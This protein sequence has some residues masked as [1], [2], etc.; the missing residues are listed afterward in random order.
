[1]KKYKICFT[2]VLVSVILLM[3][4]N[5]FAIS[6]KKTY[7][8]FIL[9][10]KKIDQ[11]EA[12]IEKQMKRGKIPGI[13]V[14]VVKGDKVIYKKGFGYSDLDTKQPVTTDTLFEMGSTSKA[15]SALGIYQ[16]EDK[17]LLSLK[18]PVKKYLPWL[19]MEY[20]GTFKGEEIDGFV[21][22]TLQQLLHHTSGIPFK[23]IGDIPAS[24]RED[25]L[26]K[27]VRK[28]L[29][30]KLDSYPGERYSY[31][32]INYDVLGLVIQQVSG[33]SFEDY[34]KE[35]VIQPIGLKNTVLFRDEAIKRDMSK[36][37]KI[38]YL[39]P[40]KYDAPMYR[41]NTPAGYFITNAEDMI[42]WLRIQLGIE[43]LDNF[44]NDI[45]KKS[46]IPDRSVS[47]NLDGSSYAGGWSV[48][49]NGGGEISH[50]G[51][52][53]NFSSFIVFRPED[54][55]GVAVLANLNSIYTQSIGQGIINMIQGND[56]MEIN[57]DMYRNLDSIAVSIILIMS[58]IFLICL[59]MTINFFIQLYKKE[60]KFHGSKSKAVIDSTLFLLFITGFGYC[61]YYIPN[62]LFWELPW[63]FV[64][65]WAPES[66]MV[67]IILL[68]FTVVLLSLY[69]LLTKNFVKEDDKSIFYITTL[70]IVSGFGNAF[71]IFLINEALNRS[72]NFT[73][74]LL[75]Y[76]VMALIIYIYGQK[77]VRVKLT[78]ITNNLVYS[79]RV[80][81]I[82][83][84]LNTSYEKMEEIG[85]EKI[86]ACLNNDT[87]TISNFANII[88]TGATSLVTLLCCFAYLG[89]INF[90]GLLVSIVIIFM[91]ACLYFFAGVSANR[92]WEQ[93]RNIQAT[94]FKFINDMLNGFKELYIHNKKRDEFKQD[95]E[96]SCNEYKDK[97]IK[98]DL[99]FTNAFIIGE[100]LFTFVIGVV[101]FIF[102][103]IFTNIQKGGLRNYVLVFLYMTGPV[104]SILEAI[105]NLTKVRIS[106]NRIN[107]LTKEIEFA[108]IKSIKLENYISGKELLYL[109]LRDIE[110]SYKKNENQ[111]FTVGPINCDFKAG[112][113]TFITGGNGSGKSSLAKLITGLYRPNKGH[114]YL[115]GIQIGAEELSQ[116][117]STIFSD[118]HLFD[119]LYGID[120]KN[121]MRETQEYLKI[122]SIDN[123]LQ[124]NDGIFSTTNLST[125]QRKRIALLISYLENRPIYLFDEWAADQDP[126]FRKFFYYTL[127]PKLRDEGKCIIAI[128]H[129]D[130]YFD[131]ADKFIKMDMGKIVDYNNYN[132]SDEVI[133]ET[134][135]S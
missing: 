52:N 131:V 123:K 115:N 42:K 125:G 111:E 41:G 66:F 44:N 68:F 46:H 74:G 106:W 105:P 103:I 6:Y 134:M 19:Q 3:T 88:I 59:W 23:T 13:S 64:K 73:S 94:F 116:K 30:T 31:A 65:V 51:S 110:Y 29:E 4:M 135:S 25:A 26:E 119:R 114:I 96:E 99:K 118:F 50:G 79:K 35:N 102:P 67:S 92:L 71:I 63:S 112:E 83:R 133:K 8:A 54:K 121:K 1:M 69:F 104:R 126:E 40:L 97:R 76:F 47:P 24:N 81:L 85:N 93:T 39:Q 86:Y 38:G 18:D 45:I 128:T 34:M 84:I 9:S 72:S 87:E 27:T 98:G 7:N 124:V 108:E 53:P 127:L 61:L 57:S 17:G 56:P 109:E 101:V 12:F 15:F 43:D 78:T 2:V 32:T 122:L 21:D 90:Y 20:E 82:N 11:I 28:L 16:L 70:S 120:Y 5:T 58:F 95:M 130:K 77:G 48:Y 37:Y 89:I 22:I 36:G 49:Q 132:I 80:K 91:A 100:I 129:D 14:T 10:D 62:V 113:I 117:F 75:L 60:R 33:Q 107:E 55:L